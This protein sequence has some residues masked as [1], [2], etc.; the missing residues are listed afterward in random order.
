MRIGEITKDNYADY[1]KLFGGKSSKA[2]DE[3]MGKDKENKYQKTEEEKV[4]MLIRQGYIM[5]GM[6]VKEGDVSWRKIV[7]I[8]DDMKDKIHDLLKKEFTE[9]NGMSD[10][11]AFRALT[12]DYIKNSPVDKR[13]S[14]SWTIDQIWIEEA[15]R[16]REVVTSNNPNW[17]PGQAFDPSIFDGYTSG[18][19]DIRA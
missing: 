6:Y 11:E 17:K 13:L 18:G 15:Q 19:I 2:L 4:E 12:K 8:A 10:G 9:N 16:L 3:M 7:P 14:V 1:I 5:E